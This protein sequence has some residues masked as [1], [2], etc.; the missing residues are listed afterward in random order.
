MSQQPMQACEPGA[1]PPQ[2]GRGPPGAPAAVPGGRGVVILRET[3]SQTA[4]PYV[5]IGL[6][7]QHAGFDIFEIN[8][9]SVL[10]TPQTLGERIRIEGTVADGSGTLVRDVLIEIWRRGSGE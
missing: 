9:G 10:A 5:H 8:F 4:G 3:A 1:G 6:A 2:G 7:P